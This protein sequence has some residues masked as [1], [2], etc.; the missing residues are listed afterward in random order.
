M[1]FKLGETYKTKNGLDVRMLEVDPRDSSLRGSDGYWREAE[2]PKA[3]QLID[4]TFGSDHPLSLVVPTDA[5][6]HDELLAL[7]AEMKAVLDKGRPI[8]P[9]SAYH[10][11]MKVIP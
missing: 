5:P 10:R 8:E 9:T 7:L 4:S 11:A 6:T 1:R 3:G 2:G